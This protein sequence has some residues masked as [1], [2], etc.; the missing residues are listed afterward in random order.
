STSNKSV[1]Q[2]VKRYQRM[3]CFLSEEE[4]SFVEA[5][6]EKNK[7]SN[8]SRWLRETILLFIHK[9]LNDKYPTLFDEHD[10]RR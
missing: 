1:C 3:T 5:Y 9:D 8:R 10:M 7:I 6:L 4:L 2:E